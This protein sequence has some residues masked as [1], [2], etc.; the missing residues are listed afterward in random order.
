MDDAMRFTERASHREPSMS[1][2]RGWQ[3][4]AQKDILTQTD[5]GKCTA[6]CA[7]APYY[8]VDIHNTTLLRI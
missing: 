5:S 4:Q 1:F 7:C 3:R 2:Y 6:H 8:K